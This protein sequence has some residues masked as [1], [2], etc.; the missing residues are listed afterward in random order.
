[1]TRPRIG[2]VVR[3][4]RDAP[5]YDPSMADQLLQEKNEAATVEFADQER[6]QLF[7]DKIFALV[8]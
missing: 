7:A 6:H 8:R 1:M 4:K 5:R 2:I 3:K